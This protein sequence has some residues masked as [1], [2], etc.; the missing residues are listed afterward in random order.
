MILIIQIKIIHPLEN[1][2]W[3]DFKSVRAKPAL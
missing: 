1:K 3:Q 2:I